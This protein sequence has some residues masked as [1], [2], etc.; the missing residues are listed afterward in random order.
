MPYF[1]STAIYRAEYNQA[2][3]TLS[4]WF[5]SNDGP[6]DYYGV[7]QFHFDRLCSARSVGQYFNR[8]IRHQYGR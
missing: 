7:P 4:I 5:T 8:H 3:A 1:H 2:T 6:Y